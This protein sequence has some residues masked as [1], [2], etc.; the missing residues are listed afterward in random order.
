MHSLQNLQNPMRGPAAGFHNS[1]LFLTTVS[2]RFAQQVSSR[3]RRIFKK[4]MQL[5]RHLD[6]KYIHSKE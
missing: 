5:K 3:L 6:A 4:S 1:S 2:T